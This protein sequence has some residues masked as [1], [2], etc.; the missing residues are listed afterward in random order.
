M[1][2]YIILLLSIL[3]YSSGYS[4]SVTVTG[5]IK[6]QSGNA[7]AFSNIVFTDVLDAKKVFGCLS[8]EDGSFE[9]EIPN[10][11]YNLKVSVIG[12]KSAFRK[13]DLRSVKNKKDI[14]EIIIDVNINLKEVIITANTSAHKI[15]LD[16]KTYTVTKDIAN[17]GGSLIDVMENVPS[18]QVNINGSISIRGSGNIQ[19]LIDG[20]ISDL[21]DATA[22]L[23]TIPA[24]SIDKIEVITNPSSKYSSEGSGGI[25]NVILKKG[26]EKKLSSSIELF[27]GVR[28]NSGTNLSINKGNEKYSWYVNSGLGYSEPKRTGKVS[29]EYLTPVPTNY[30]QNDTSLLK[31]FYFSNTMGGQLSLNDKST[32]SSDVTYR[33]SNFNNTNTIAYQDFERSN[34]SATSKRIDDEKNK[35]SFYKISSEYK[36]KLNERGSQLKIGLMKQSSTEKGQSSILESNSIPISSISSNDFISNDVIDNRYNFDIDYSHTRKDNSQIELG[37]RIRNANIR[38]NFSVERTI[39]NSSALIPEFTDRTTYKENVIAIY[40]Q[41]AKSYKKF[42]F[43]VGLRSETTNIEMFSNNNTEKTSKNYTDVFPSSFFDYEF[44]DTNSL[45][46]SLSRRIRRPN[47]NAITSFNSFSDSRNIF[48]G[49]P[50]INPSYVILAELGY[51]SKISSN[52][53]ITPTIF[54]RNTKDVMHYFVQ[55]E[56]IT[57]NGILKEVFVTK[58]INVGDNNALGLELNTSYAPFNWLKMYNELTISGFKQSGKVNGIDYNS[59]GVFIYGKFNM[60]F[61]ISKSIKFQMQHWFANGRKRGQIDSNGIYRMDLGLSKSLFKDNAS[62]TLNMKDIF[63]TWEWHTVKEGD[64]FV[65]INDTQ[66]R[67]PQ[68]NV[69]FIYRFN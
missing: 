62:L 4:Q 27:S 43:Q 1:K 37:F 18:V 5:K 39:D 65:Q 49:N 42:K 60:N 10:L 32:I 67:T 66:M 7:A 58:T 38:N 31:Q 6:D 8:N 59:K 64:N 14:G 12:L 44:N 2:A 29:V 34:L 21:T 57:F 54:Y 55:N 24:G 47:R 25:I 22:L 50:S 28:L 11:L 51:Q 61:T 33:S 56:E 63:D 36:L 16:K 19:I 17:N 9:I 48:A 68:F 41:Y 52:L 45:R 3:C 35:N 69:S 40:S 46:L 23:K 20:K 53:S 15:E 30:L 13:I 26:K